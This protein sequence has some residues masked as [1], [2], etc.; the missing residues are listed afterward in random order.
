[1]NNPFLKYVMKDKKED[2]FHSSAYGRVQ[3]GASMGAA[4]SRSF[5]ERRE[6][7]ENRKIVGGFGQSGIMGQAAMSGP[8][9]KTFTPPPSG[10]LKK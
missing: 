10:G 6:A 7:Q 9:P 4:S 2:I 5:T 1:M 8:R 3:N